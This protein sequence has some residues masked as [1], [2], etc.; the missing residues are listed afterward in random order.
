MQRRLIQ[1]NK[2]VDHRTWYHEYQ[3]EFFWAVQDPD[4]PEFSRIVAQ[5]ID[6]P[7]EDPR[8]PY[9]DCKWTSLS[10]VW[11]T[12]K[13]TSTLGYGSKVRVICTNGEEATKKWL[14]WDKGWA[15]I[16]VG[17]K[18]P[19]TVSYWRHFFNFNNLISRL[20]IMASAGVEPEFF[21]QIYLPD[22]KHLGLNNLKPKWNPM[23]DIL[24]KI[25]EIISDKL[26]LDEKTIEL[27]SSLKNDLG[28]DSLDLIE[29]IM[30]LESE[31]KIN[32]DE[33][34]LPDNVFVED[35]QKAV[36]ELN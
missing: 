33:T 5:K 8:I 21:K 36:V 31:F 2:K 14:G 15:P 24:P 23:D 18:T 32:I 25:K 3:G 29:I 28:A 1:I 26:A 10:E 7:V 16:H 11:H 19:N 9:S 30:D 17:D 4:F 12:S 6:L 13:D 34:E 20:Y 27:K 35:L 22:L